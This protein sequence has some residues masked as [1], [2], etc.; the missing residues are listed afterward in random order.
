M[1]R[2]VGALAVSLVVLTAGRAHAQSLISE[3]A[4][5]EVGGVYGIDQTQVSE[6]GSTVDS[7]EFIGEGGVSLGSV[8]V[9]SSGGVPVVLMSTNESQRAI[10]S[11][12]GSNDP[13]EG[14]SSAS[15]CHDKAEEMQDAFEEALGALDAGVIGTTTLGGFM[16]GGGIVL[17]VVGTGGG[18]LVILGLVLTGGGVG[19]TLGGGLGFATIELTDPMIIN[20]WESYLA[21]WLEGCLDHVDNG[22]TGGPAPD[23]DPPNLPGGGFEPGYVD[24]ELGTCLICHEFGTELVQ[25]GATFENGEVT[26]SAHT[27]VV[28]TRWSFSYGRDSNGDGF[29]D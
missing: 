27:E 20:D 25:D 17:F 18:G 12:G 14:M 2:L 7:V 13:Y 29:C 15:D 16:I 6:G 11:S 23:P 1:M 21:D 9:R 28:C 10:S 26:V 19:A 5:F 24:P 22:G 4:V 3:A 8:A